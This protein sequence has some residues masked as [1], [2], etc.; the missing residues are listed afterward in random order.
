MSI[1]KITG[2]SFW[3]LGCYIFLPAQPS[4][5]VQRFTTD[6]GLPSNGIKGLQ[7]DEQTGFLW[8]ATEAGIVRFNGTDFLLF[9]KANC[10]GMLSER[11]L[12][13]LKSH[14][15]RIFTADE[16]GDLFFV[17]RNG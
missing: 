8:I 1:I 14:A 10:P 7:W 16:T 6:N 2:L 15:G 4:Y 12:F 17:V 3:L 11:M 5:H 9:N 13:L